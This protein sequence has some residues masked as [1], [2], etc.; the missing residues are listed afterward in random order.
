V[1]P[2][3]AEIIV[4]K[5]GKNV[6]GKLIEKTDKYIK[7]YFKG[8]PLTYYFEDIE[9]I[10]GER[11]ISPV[12]GK[13]ISQ[14]N[15]SVGKGYDIV[16]GGARP[17][18]GESSEHYTKGLRYSD[19]KKFVSAIEEFKKVLQKV[20]AYYEAYICI[21]ISYLHLGDYQQAISNL[22]KALEIEPKDTRALTN[23]GN[24]YRGIKKYQQAIA[25]YKEAIGIDSKFDAAYGCL[26]SIYYELGKY[27]EARYYY[28]EAIGLF[29]ANGDYDGARQIEG[30]LKEIPRN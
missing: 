14:G 27:E 30:Y 25:Y 4:L 12:I 17:L 21:G 8:V 7:I 28:R 10:D 16:R 5:S 11:I 9:S 24:A 15:L 22:Q 20:P 19:E 2:A 18:D 26:G 6:E 13:E 3:F 29:K 1:T 23:L